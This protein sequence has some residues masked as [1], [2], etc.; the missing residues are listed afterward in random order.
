M[1]RIRQKEQQ[2]WTDNCNRETDTQAQADT[3]GEEMRRYKK[4]EKKRDLESIIYEET[5]MLRE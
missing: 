3:R 4:Q 1:E 2:R 5:E